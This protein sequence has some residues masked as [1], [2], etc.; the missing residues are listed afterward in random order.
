MK[1]NMYKSVILPA[2]GCEIWPATL[3][4]ENRLIVSKSRVRRVAGPGQN[5]VADGWRKTNN[6]ELHNLYCSQYIIR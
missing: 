2:Y 3:R 1:I 5:E 4:E 6:G